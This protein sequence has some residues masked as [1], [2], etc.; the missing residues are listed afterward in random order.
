[1]VDS[2]HTSWRLQLIEHRLD[3]GPTLR[4]GTRSSRTYIQNGNRRHPE[5]GEQYRR[6]VHSTLGIREN[7]TECQQRFELSKNGK[8][9]TTSMEIQNWDPISNRYFLFESYDAGAGAETHS[10]RSGGWGWGGPVQSARSG[11]E[12]GTTS[13]QLFA[14]PFLPEQ[15]RRS[16]RSVQTCFSSSSQVML[17]SNLNLSN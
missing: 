16:S 2:T 17:I 3:L 8:D 11:I 7:R 15:G 1:L 9:F 10:R 14:T 13:T 6:S 5:T 4:T 12:V